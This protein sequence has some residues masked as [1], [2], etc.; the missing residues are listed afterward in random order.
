MATLVLGISGSTS[1]TAKADATCVSGGICVWTGAFYTG[2]FSEP[3]CNAVGHIGA[4]FS[5]KNRCPWNIRMGWWDGSSVNWKFCM[6][7]GGER[8]DPGRFNYVGGC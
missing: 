4:Q 1:L 3:T 5:A 8:P 6:N 2:T 7:P